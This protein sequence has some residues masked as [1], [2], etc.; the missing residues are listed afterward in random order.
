M[1]SQLTSILESTFGNGHNYH[2]LHYQI[3]HDH[4]ITNYLVLPIP[5]IKIISKYLDEFISNNNHYRLIR[6]IR[7]RYNI[8]V[9]FNLTKFQTSRIFLENI[10]KKSNTEQLD[11]LYEQLKLYGNYVLDMNIKYDEIIKYIHDCTEKNNHY[12]KLQ[13]IE[14]NQK[15]E[16]MKYNECSHDKI[17]VIKSKQ[18]E[19][20]NEIENFDLND[21][22]NNIYTMFNQYVVMKINNEKQEII[23]SKV[24]DYITNTI[25]TN[26]FRNLTDYSKNNGS[27]FGK[28]YE[29][30]I[31]DNLKTVLNHHGFE[32]IKNVELTFAM[33]F[34]GIKLEYDFMIG[35]IIDQTFIVYAVFDAKISKALI[36][37][38]IDKFVTSIDYLMQNKLTLRQRHSFK[39]ILAVPDDKIIIGYFCQSEINYKKEI[40]KSISTY[41][42]NNGNKTLELLEGCH[43]NFTLEMLE[44]ICRDIMID[45]HEF[46]E[47]LKKHQTCVFNVN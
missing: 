43:I 6:N 36:H 21:M 15:I 35:K 18:F 4:D 3:N 31:F 13:V 24:I 10:F 46:I 37:K 29:N 12:L 40:S 33:E 45:N 39:N 44:N 8:K 20:E 47:T 17:E 5:F 19:I 25:L 11:L 41:L 2:D 23:K 1:N 22:E 34:S 16:R 26:S 27:S 32:I 30:I 28:S 42:I 38:D 7:N 9:K 14:L